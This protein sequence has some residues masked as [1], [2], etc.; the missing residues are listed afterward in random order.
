MANIPATRITHADSTSSS[1]TDAFNGRASVWT[2]RVITG[3]IAAFLL[4]DGIAKLIPLQPVVDG[5]LKVGK[6]GAFIGD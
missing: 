1:S 2:G 5:T 4:V 3:L 6:M